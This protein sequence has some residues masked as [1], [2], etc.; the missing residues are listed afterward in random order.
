MYFET[1]GGD[2]NLQPYKKYPASNKRI[3]CARFCQNHR[4]DVSHLHIQPQRWNSSQAQ[5]LGQ[6]EETLRMSPLSFLFS[7]SRAFLSTA[8]AEELSRSARKKPPS[9]CATKAP[10]ALHLRILKTGI[11]WFKRWNFRSFARAQT[12]LLGLQNHM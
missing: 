12:R 9:R 11:S 8:S 5:C 3:P 6:H 4:G 7:M 10:E 1:L 2:G